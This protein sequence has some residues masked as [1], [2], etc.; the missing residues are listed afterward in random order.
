MVGRR[1]MISPAECDA[2]PRCQGF[3]VREDLKD[4]EGSEYRLGARCMNCGNVID[5]VIAERKARAT[6]A[7]LQEP[8]TT[9]IVSIRVS[10][11]PDPAEPAS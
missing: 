1:L 6:V 5:P 2:C 7:R 3:L 10:L 11:L 4:C 8:R 9:Q